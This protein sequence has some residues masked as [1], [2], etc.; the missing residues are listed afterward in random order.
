MT[1]RTEKLGRASLFLTSETFV[2]PRVI[3][4]LYVTLAPGEEALRLLASSSFVERTAAGY[5]IGV[6]LSSLASEDHQR[7]SQF[8]SRIPALAAATASSSARLRP[9]APG[10]ATALVVVS[11]ALSPRT[12]EALQR[13]GV[14]VECVPSV[15]RAAER[16]HSG[17]V[18][19]IVCDLQGAEPA[20]LELCAQLRDKSPEV[21]VML[22]TRR[23]QEEDFNSGLQAGAATVIG[24]PCGQKLLVTRILDLY[25]GESV[26]RSVSCASLAPSDLTGAQ[27]SPQSEP[28]PG[29]RSVLGHLSSW[30]LA[31]L[32]G[33]RQIFGS[34][35]G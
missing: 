18:K 32:L 14:E 5:G 3:F 25:H 6:E 27:R 34:A 29:R 20:G 21:R 24:K 9:V 2:P 19:M 30:A 28:A 22:L 11:Q 13:A 4:E 26:E 1:M 10:R 35:G 31:G 7:W 33:A 12:V 15:D 8:L 17:A 16:A 23:D